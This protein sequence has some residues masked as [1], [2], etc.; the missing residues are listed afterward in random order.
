M[1]GGTPTRSAYLAL[2]E[3]R[4]G[5]HEG[6]RF[7]DEKR[8][9]LAAGMISQLGSYQA[10][11]HQL[12]VA[13][14]EAI[15]SLRGAVARHGLT[16]LYHYP[17]LPGP[18][19]PLTCRQE[20][21][22]GGGTLPQRFCPAA[23]AV[24]ETGGVGRQSVAPA[25][26][27]P[28]HRAA[29]QGAGGC[30]AAGVGRAAQVSRWR[31]GGTGKGRSDPCPPLWRRTTGLSRPVKVPYQTPAQFASPARASGILGVPR[32]EP[33]SHS[34]KRNTASTQNRFG[35]AAGRAELRKFVVRPG[36]LHPGP[37]RRNF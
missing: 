24:G 5:M 12:R 19:Q 35:P 29:G 4:Q 26:R 14:A 22:S 6:Y 28:P 23:A 20:S 15:R 2:R 9:A 36:G 37:V 32:Q 30:A 18:E 1:N 33:R 8:L 21:L 11:E 13:Y 17:P 25:R 16:G 10:L 34:R 27:I 31:P 3:E 7:L